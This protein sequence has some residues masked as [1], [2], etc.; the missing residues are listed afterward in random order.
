MPPWTRSEV[1]VLRRIVASRQ[2]LANMSYFALETAFPDPENAYGQNIF[3]GLGLSRTDLGLD[4]Y[5]KPGDIDVL[6]VPVRGSELLTDRTIALETK[7]V[8]P[9]IG[10][11][12]RNVSTFG[13]TQTK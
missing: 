10:K 9:T 11:P 7:I 13:V 4:P 5:R 1:E 3:V 2:L 12:S 6:V 8:R